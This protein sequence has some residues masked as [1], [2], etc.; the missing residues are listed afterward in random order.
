MDTEQLDVELDRIESSFASALGE[1]IRQAGYI[2]GT[3][4]TLISI[5]MELNPEVSMTADRLVKT[6]RGVEGVCTQGLKLEFQ[7]LLDLC[8]ALQY[9]LEESKKVET[10]PLTDLDSALNAL[11][12]DKG[13]KK[14][15]K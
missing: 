12:K 14:N 11:T 6:F 8:R 1:F 3:L 13:T 5:T 4:D 7:R 2:E 9:Q 10:N 15:G